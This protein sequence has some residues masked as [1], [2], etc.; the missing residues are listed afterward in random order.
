VV[1]PAPGG[2]GLAVATCL[3]LIVVLFV[4]LPIAGVAIYG[5]QIRDVLIEIGN[6]V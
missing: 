6:S 3:I 1:Q 2:S 5:D 4:L